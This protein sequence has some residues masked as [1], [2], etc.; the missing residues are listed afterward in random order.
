MATFPTITADETGVWCQDAPNR[1]WGI[2]WSEIVRVTVGKIDTITSVDTSVELDFEF[3]EW[4]ELS[5][6]FPGFAEAMRTI[7]ERLGCE[8]SDWVARTASLR[9]DDNP[10]VLWS[11]LPGS[12]Q[13]PNRAGT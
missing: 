7:C 2:L 11:R 10:F 12:A 1:R 6:A 4:I 8:H 3:G 5:S 9:P 13:Q